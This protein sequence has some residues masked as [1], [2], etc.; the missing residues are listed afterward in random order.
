MPDY[1]GPTDHTSADAVES[2][3]R[4]RL[5]RDDLTRA[6]R[7]AAERT[8]YY[9]AAHLWV[10]AGYAVVPIRPGSKAPVIEWG[11]FSRYSMTA[12]YRRFTVDDLYEYAHRFPDANAALILDS[13]PDHDLIAGDIDDGDRRK[14]QVLIDALGPG[15][16]IITRTRRQGGG[17]QLI[18]RSLV[19]HL[20]R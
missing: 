1:T 12:L 20:R 14:L 4:G 16:Q 7:R 9:R 2:R 3:R 10:Q 17:F 13:H 18:G 19:R 6:E 11:E 5:T 15:S 8:R